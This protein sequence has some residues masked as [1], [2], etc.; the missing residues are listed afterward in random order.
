MRATCLVSVIA[1]LAAAA[2]A[3]FG[4]TIHVP[5][6]YST[7]QGAIDASVNGDLIVIAIGTY[8]ENLDTKGKAITLQG[9]GEEI[10]TVDGGQNGTCIKFVSGETNSTVI[11]SMGFKHGTGVLIA[12]I[13][14]GGGMYIA[15]KSSPL[16]KNSG[17]GFNTAQ[18]GAGVF[19]ARG[20]NPVF[21]DDLV[22]NNFTGKKG[23]GGGM[24]VCG[25]STI[26]STRVAE[27]GAPNGGGGGVFLDNTKTTFTNGTLS[28]NFAF[29]GGGIQVNKGSP[30]ITGNWFE[31]NTV[32]SAPSNGEGAG[33][34]ITGK[35]TAYVAFNEFEKNTAHN[36]GGVYAYDSTP[37]ISQNLIHNNTADLG[38]GFGGGVT[39]GKL[40]AAGI[41]DRNQIY[42]NAASQG[43][44]VSIRAG[45]T[46]TIY[47]NII[48][49]NT[50]HG[51]TGFGG[52]VYSLESAS[53]A[54][55]NTIVYNHATNGGGVWVSGKSAPVIDTSIIYFNSATNNSSFFDGSGLLILTYADVETNV[56]GAGD[57]SVD[58]LFTNA[59][60]RDYTLQSTSLLIDAGNTTLNPSGTDI[61]GNS[62]V[63]GGRIDMG[64]AEH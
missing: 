30:I 37:T 16:I 28:Q 48:D 4:G 8:H 9:A 10:T 54:P 55:A 21:Q 18:Y 53:P 2:P 56:V 19:V 3:A 47:G 6:D 24:Y 23:L 39:F 26:D 1:A 32:L 51:I 44:G 58:P 35:S 63:V 34:G 42:L 22:A 29:Y 13:P 60:N 27:N 59:S 15:N 12:G 17:I 7:I 36:G 46:A 31:R 33:I 25:D 11:D 61:Y 41:L 38:I 40:G 20:C 57:I 64:A 14:V 49:N 62:R 50:A 52:G 43:G 5:A 45:T